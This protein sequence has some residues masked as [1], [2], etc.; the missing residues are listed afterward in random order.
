M[1]CGVSL[2]EL[3]GAISLILSGVR[4]M[5]LIINQAETNSGEL[6]TEN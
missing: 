1:V 6:E 3:K 2:K 4:E 5:V